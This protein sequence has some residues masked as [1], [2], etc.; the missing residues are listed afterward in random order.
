MIS[1]SPPPNP[2]PIRRGDDPA[3]NHAPGFSGSAS[4]GN[5]ST[6]R[7]SCGIDTTP[8]PGGE[9]P[10]LDERFA[11]AW[12]NRADHRVCGRLLRP[13]CLQH[14]LALQL[15]QSPFV[16]GEPR[17]ITWADVFRAAAICACGFEELPRFAT[18]YSMVNYVQG[19]RLTRWLTRGR[20]GRDL[21]AEAHRFRA[22]QNDYQAEPDLFFETDG[23]E[24]TAPALLG[25]AVYLQRV[26]GLDEARVWTMPLGKALWTYATALEQEQ[27]G[28]SL[29]PEGEQD[30]M[31][32]I[33]AIQ[34]G[35]IP[36][37]PELQPGALEKSGAPAR[38][39]P[40]VFGPA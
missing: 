5:V 14:A 21:A 39:D 37:P 35:R 10:T 28:V 13:Y 9:R 24:L 2:P 36:L 15:I 34:E 30:V 22:Y 3:A 12:L 16:A 6:P 19:H 20:R 31:D 38:I 29:L 8:A 4:C 23:K 1:D 32:W 26:V 18:S 7:A 25:R 17:P 11:E 33:K 40:A 27:P